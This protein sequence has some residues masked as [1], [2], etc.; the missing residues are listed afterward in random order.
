VIAPW[1]VQVCAINANTGDISAQ[2]GCTSLYHGFLIWQA[3]MVYIA[4]LRGVCYI[5]PNGLAA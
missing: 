3:L 1:R 4:K 5:I 2:V